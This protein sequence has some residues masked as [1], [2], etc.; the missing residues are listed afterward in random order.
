MNREAVMSIAAKIE[1]MKPDFTRMS[2]SI[3]DFAELKFEEKQSAGMLASA[4]EENG[5]AVRRGVA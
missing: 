2:D 5:F 4:L 1:A 3:W